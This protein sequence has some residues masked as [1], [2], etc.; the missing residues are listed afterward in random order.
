MQYTCIQTKFNSLV[1]QVPL[2]IKQQ[3]H[4]LDSKHILKTMESKHL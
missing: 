4:S 3:T 1:K 2:G